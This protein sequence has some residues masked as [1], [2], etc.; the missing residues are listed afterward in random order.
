MAEP[1]LLQGLIRALQWSAKGY[2]LVDW[3]GDSRR[4]DHDMSCKAR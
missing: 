1:R 3:L 4:A 2:R